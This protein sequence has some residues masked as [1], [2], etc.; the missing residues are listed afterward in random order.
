V[1]ETKPLREALRPILQIKNKFNRGIAGK[2]PTIR[3]LKET[4]EVFDPSTFNLALNNTH[5]GFEPS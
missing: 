4:G 2:T 5:K 3:I 1:E